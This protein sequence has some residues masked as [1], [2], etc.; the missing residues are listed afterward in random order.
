MH[1]RR[2]ATRRE[3]NLEPDVKEVT[4]LAGGRAETGN[5]RPAVGLSDRKANRLLTEKRKKKRTR[6][7]IYW[8]AWSAQ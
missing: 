7:Q 4:L 6:N 2:D 3:R 1:M 5:V 8:R